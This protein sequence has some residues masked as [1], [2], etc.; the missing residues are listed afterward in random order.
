VQVEILTTTLNTKCLVHF[1]PYKIDCLR[2]GVP[3]NQGRPENGPR[4]DEQSNSN[5]RP[6][7]SLDGSSAFH[8][9]EARNKVC[10][11]MAVSSLNTRQCV[12]KPEDTLSNGM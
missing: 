11:A 8:R 1:T 6:V 3:Q 2:A 12:S 4:P 5:P 9:L 10:Q 7:T